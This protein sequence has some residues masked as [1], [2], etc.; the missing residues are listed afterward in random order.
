MTTLAGL[1]LLLAAV[2]DIAANLLLKASDGFRRPLLGVGAVGLVWGAFGFLALSLREVPLGIAYAVWGAL[3]ILGTTL[4]S[5][6]L[7]GVRFTRRAWAGIG[8]L[9]LS[10]ATL[11]LSL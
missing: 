7:E 4:I 11:H 8:L 3:G 6:R 10:V 9:L 5:H 2:L 1:C